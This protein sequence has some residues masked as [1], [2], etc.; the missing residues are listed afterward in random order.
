MLQHKKLQQIRLKTGKRKP[1][2]S[3][4]GLA[5]T[6]LSKP[7]TTAASGPHSTTPEG[8]GVEGSAESRKPVRGDTMMHSRQGCFYPVQIASPSLFVG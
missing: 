3:A 2:E 8:R 6:D 4:N 7:T 1:A 5:T